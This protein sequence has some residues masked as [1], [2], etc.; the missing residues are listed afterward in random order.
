MG[1]HQR[2]ADGVTRRRFLTGAGQYTDDVTVAHS[3]DIVT[4]QPLFELG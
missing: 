3:V 1:D 2:P 4:P